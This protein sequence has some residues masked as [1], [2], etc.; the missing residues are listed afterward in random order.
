M[1]EPMTREE[2]IETV[3][4]MAK[5]QDGYAKRATD[6]ALK[7]IH[8]ANAKAQRQAADFLLATM[9]ELEQVKGEQ[10][11]D[12]KAHEKEIAI[13]S[14][15]YA[16]LERERDILRADR[17]SAARMWQASEQERE[18][19]VARARE[20]SQYL[21]IETQHAEAA[22]TALAAMTEREGVVRA[23]LTDLLAAYA[24]PDMQICCNGHDCG[25]RG[26]TTR[27]MA[28]HYARAALQ[29]KDATHG[30]E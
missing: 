13:W 12:R 3:L 21:A 25:C 26:S 27:D 18:A 30:P 16:A 29:H 6:P 23:A 9:T 11:A 2:A 28:E 5:V 7:I 22:D 8:K 15:N 20:A 14:E 24:E 19:A 4:A 17:D 10:A 1:T